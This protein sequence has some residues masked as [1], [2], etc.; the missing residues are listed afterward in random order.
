MTLKEIRHMISGRLER[1]G[2]ESADYESWVF[3]DWKL[4]VSRADY[5]L[6]PEAEIP[7]ESLQ[8]LEEV[9]RK[10]ENRFPLQYLMGTC[11]FM[12]YTF[13]VDER[14]LIPRHDTE[15][16]VEEILRYV[17]E[18]ADKEETSESGLRLLD[19]CTGSGCIGIS[20]KL[21]CPQLDVTLC[22][23]SGDAVDAAAANARDLG[24][25]VSLLQGDLFD[26]LAV[27]DT[28]KRTFDLIVSN[29]PYIPCLEL[30][31]LMPEVKDHEPLMALDGK[32]DGLFFYRRITEE[33]AG[34]L[35]RGGRLFFEI[36]AD[37]AKE[38]KDL[39]ISNGFMEVSVRK[40]LAG[41]DRIICGRLS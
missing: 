40:D 13:H 3:M 26:A 36:G 35:R 7:E 41:L 10:R 27:H 29:P 24:A 39:M 21:L 32:G 38:V 22:D 37:Q 8:A 20:L 4:D 33:A 1:A 15:C 16:L 5:Y 18:D 28:E 34:C 19:L 25:D 6:N 14:V 30:K 12:G 17:R 23:L 11:E 9:L 2:I 31:E